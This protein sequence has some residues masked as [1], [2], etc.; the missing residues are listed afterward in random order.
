MNSRE[1]S[2]IHGIEECE[3]L[4]ILV[5]CSAFSII[6]FHLIS[7]IQSRAVSSRERIRCDRRRARALG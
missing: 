1:T 4:G 5:F 7:S 6:G 2:F 3:K